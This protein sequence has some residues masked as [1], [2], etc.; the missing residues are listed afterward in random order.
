MTD[1]RWTKV[2]RFACAEH[3]PLSEDSVKDPQQIQIQ[4]AQREL[5]A[6]ASAEPLKAALRDM[7]SEREAHRSQFELSMTL[8]I[9]TR[10]KLGSL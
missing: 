6:R 3:V 5:R 9:F 8:H 4:I 2:D 1:R 7:H 10:W